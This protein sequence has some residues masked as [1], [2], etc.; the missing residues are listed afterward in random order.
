[1]NS[2]AAQPQVTNLAAA[3]CPP[4]TTQ[5]K[6]TFFSSCHHQSV[7]TLYILANCCY[8]MAFMCAICFWLAAKS[9]CVE[10]A[11]ERTKVWKIFFKTE[12]ASLSYC[13]DIE[14]IW[15]IVVTCRTPLPFAR[16]SNCPRPLE[17]CF[18]P[19]F[20]AFLSVFLLVYSAILEGQSSTGS[21]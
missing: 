2:N 5:K 19:N 15:E 16:N 7:W 4:S 10:F 6:T 14:R 1:M 17:F 12:K 20:A 3:L 18:W 9:L 8:K 11:E 21:M 13:P